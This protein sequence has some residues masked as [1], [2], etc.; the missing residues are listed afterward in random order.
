MKHFSGFK[1]APVVIANPPQVFVAS[2]VCEMS[3]CAVAETDRVACI[4]LVLSTYKIAARVRRGW[5]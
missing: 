3:S 2:C 5:E 4:I 1:A